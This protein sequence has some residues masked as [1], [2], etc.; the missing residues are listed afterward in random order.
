[1]DFLTVYRRILQLE[2]EGLKVSRGDRKDI[3]KMIFHRWNEDHKRMPGQISQ[4]EDGKRFVVRAY[5]LW[6]QRKMDKAILAYFKNKTERLTDQI[7]DQTKPRNKSKLL[8]MV[9]LAQTNARIAEANMAPLPESSNRGK[10]RKYGRRKDKP[11][12]DVGTLQKS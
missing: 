3:G 12:S 4:W 1:M 9:R 11:E 2:E 7:T 6:Y 8:R 5:P 10:G